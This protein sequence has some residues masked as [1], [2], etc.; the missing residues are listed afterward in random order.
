MNIILLS[1]EKCDSVCTISIIIMKI[2]VN[3][4]NKE[5][6]ECAVLSADFNGSV[7]EDMHGDILPVINM[8]VRLC[9]MHAKE[10]FGHDAPTIVEINPNHRMLP[11]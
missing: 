4:D 7:K 8:S 1:V 10:Y 2:P 11:A 5:C 9:A 6:K 3:I